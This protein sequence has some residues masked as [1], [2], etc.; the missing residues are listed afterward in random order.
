MTSRAHSQV[1]ARGPLLWLRHRSSDPPV[2]CHACRLHGR[3][4]R[5]LVVD[6]VDRRAHARLAFSRAR[7]SAGHARRTQPEPS[8]LLLDVGEDGLAAVAGGRDVPGKACETLV[9]LL[10]TRGLA[11]RLSPYWHVQ[12]VTSLLP[13]G[14][15]A[16]GG[17]GLQLLSAEP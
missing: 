8:R 7:L 17:Q 2:R 12:S 14:E 6:L 16:P 4:H 10:Y 1:K 5:L 3:S 9:S 13:A 15:E 11:S